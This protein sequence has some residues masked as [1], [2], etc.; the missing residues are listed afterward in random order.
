MPRLLAPALLAGAGRVCFRDDVTLGWELGPGFCAGYSYIEA[1][2]PDS[3]VIFGEGCHCNN[4]VTIV[5]DGAGI[6]LGQRCLLGPDVQIYDSDFHALD[7][8][9]RATAPPRRAA[10]V[11]ADDVFVGSSAIILKGSTI[12][13]GSVVGA[14]AVVLGDVPASAIVAG[15]PARVVR[16]WRHTG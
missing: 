15:N 10:V 1:R 16:Q 8:A 5:S 2:H 7:A 9:V 3:M 11:I 14:G 6:S 13:A 12:G 4:R